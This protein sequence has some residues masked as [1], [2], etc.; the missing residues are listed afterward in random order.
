[1]LEGERNGGRMVLSKLTKDD[2]VLGD[3]GVDHV[4]SAH[5]TAGVVEHPLLLSAEVVGTNLL[6]QLGNNE[7]DDGAGVF[8]MGAYGTLGEIMQMV[9][10]EDIELFQA[11]V[12]EAVDGGEEGQEDSQETEGLEREAA[13]AA[14]GAGA[15]FGRFRRHCG[16]M[17]QWFDCGRSNKFMF[18]PLAN[19]RRQ[20]KY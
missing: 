7:V 4:H 20:A 19:R 3:T 10:V 1:M 8:T 2:Q 16:S 12:E 13:T 6:L 18:L 15:R 9:R 11:C 14:A 17:V 5:G